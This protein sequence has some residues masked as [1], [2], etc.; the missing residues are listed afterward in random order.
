VLNDHWPDMRA[1]GFVSNRIFDVGL[2]G[3][4]VISDTFAGA[5][6]FKDCIVTYETPAELRELCQRWLADEK[7][8]RA[9]ATR[10]RDRV[11]SRHTF[12]HR[13]GVIADTVAALLPMQGG[14]T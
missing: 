6:L 12:D 2:S 1:Q 7:G 3:G 8:R 5:E 13:A 4:F 11:L 14:K 10:L 9:V